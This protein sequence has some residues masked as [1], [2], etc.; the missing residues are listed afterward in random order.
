LDIFKRLKPSKHKDIMKIQLEVCAQSYV[1]AMIAQA[2]NADR[3]ELC[4]AL[5]VGGLTPSLSLILAVRR[6][7]TLPICVLVRPRAGDFVYT[8]EEF[9]IIKNDV[10]WCRD[11]GIDGVV[12]GCLDENNELDALKMKELAR[13]AYPMEVVCHKAFDRTPNL[14]LSLEK[15][16]AWGYDRVLTSGGAKNVV[17]GTAVLKDLVA[18]AEGKIEILAGGSVRADNVVELVKSTGVTQVHSSANRFYAYKNCSETDVEEVKKMIAN[19]KL[20]V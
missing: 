17:E 11:N 7:L 8:E 19:L 10:I 16:I 18:Q 6:D 15:L 1:S 20:D 9:E 14:S 4:A 12:V 3:I 5:E 13:L 2:A